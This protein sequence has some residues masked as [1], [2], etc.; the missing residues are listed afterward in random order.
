MNINKN[1][2][3]IIF[4]VFHVE[5]GPLEFPK[6]RTGMKTENRIIVDAEKYL[7]TQIS[8][9]KSSAFSIS[10]NYHSDNIYYHK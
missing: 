10:K 6:C 3:I 4:Y 2:P 8:E 7:F 9:I 1:M 5:D